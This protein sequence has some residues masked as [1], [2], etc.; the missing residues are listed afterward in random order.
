[1]IHYTSCNADA[2]LARLGVSKGKVSANN[3]GLPSIHFLA[4]IQSL[5]YP[6]RDFV[7]SD[8]LDITLGRRSRLDRFISTP[9]PSFSTS[10]LRGDS[11]HLGWRTSR[12][13]RSLFIANHHLPLRPKAQSS[14]LSE[15]LSLEFRA[16]LR[17][18]PRQPVATNTTPQFPSV[19]LSD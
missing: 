15:P 14:P 17:R 9:P 19:K 16:A 12:L 8:P 1:M 10:P 5:R 11:V 2:C 7:L 3:P 18:F 6:P 13:H 4:I